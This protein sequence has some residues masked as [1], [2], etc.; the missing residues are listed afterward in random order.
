MSYIGALGSKRSH[1][2]RVDRLKEYGFTEQQIDFI[3]AK[4]RMAIKEEA[5][6]PQLS[7]Q[8]TVD[9]IDGINPVLR[10]LIK[11][12]SHFVSESQRR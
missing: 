8:P 5:C 1:A 12:L 6:L 9:I 10:H 4:A 2:K 3:H 11:E 7:N